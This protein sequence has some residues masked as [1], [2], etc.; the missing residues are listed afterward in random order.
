MRDYRTNK[1]KK[2]ALT[3]LG[4]LLAALLTHAASAQSV[5]DTKIVTVGAFSVKVPN[6]WT[7][8]A[9]SEAAA[10][11]S[12]Y[13]EQSKQIYQQF[14]G[15][16]VDPSKSVSISAFHI[17]NDAGS[18]VIVSFTVPPQSDLIKLLKTQTPEKMDF[19][20][21][22][23]F[24]RKYLGMV[25]V[26]EGQLSGFYTKAIGTGGGIEVSGGLEHK[27]LKNTVIQLTL[28]SPKSWDETKAISS[29]TAIL[30]SVVLDHK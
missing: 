2:T 30:K 24:I 15:G 21:S 19:G 7:S 20:V 8:F 23:G 12:Q 22:Q 11:R 14:S 28:L 18:F 4:V 10:L 25:A 13:L 26:D 3:L 16:A 17:A 27:K 9:T 6:E 29:L 1:I 5:T